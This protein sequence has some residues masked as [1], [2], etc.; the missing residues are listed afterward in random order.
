MRSCFGV[1][2]YVHVYVRHILLNTMLLYVE[3]HHGVS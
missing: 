2:A 3:A 1:F